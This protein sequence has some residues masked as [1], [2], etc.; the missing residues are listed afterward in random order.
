MSRT[1]LK[2]SVKAQSETPARTSIT[3]RH[4]QFKVDEP[5]ELGGTNLAPNPVEYI[6]AGYAGCINVVA[7]LTAKELNI[8]VPG[9]TIQIEGDINPQRLFGT[10]NA[11]RAGYKQIRV[12]VTTQAAVAEP[13]KTQWLQA[14]ESRCPVNDNL[15]N[16]T[17][18]QIQ[19]H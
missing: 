10:S 13:L 14:I 5:A 18:I 7:H 6:L 8:L 16:V 9:L 17:P 15:A 19:I 4:F 1:D 3:T 11:E 12:L 2:F